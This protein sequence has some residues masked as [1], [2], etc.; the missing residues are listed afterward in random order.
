MK[1]HE[2]LVAI[3]QNGEYGYYY[4][5]PANCHF[6]GDEPDTIAD[7]DT[8]ITLA[9]TKYGGKDP[10][11]DIDVFYVDM[12]QGVEYEVH[13]E[14][15]DPTSQDAQLALERA[16]IFPTSRTTASARSSHE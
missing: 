8:E 12:V 9:T 15:L 16:A 4:T 10:G 3:S 1:L 5:P 2:R 11:Q 6:D 7:A 13:I 14:G